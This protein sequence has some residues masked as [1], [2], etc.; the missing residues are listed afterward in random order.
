[1]ALTL[2]RGQL[3]EGFHRRSALRNLTDPS[4]FLLGR[5]IIPS[6]NQAYTVEL[7]TTN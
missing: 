7:Q 4:Y 5:L 2:P 6:A 3:A 1:M